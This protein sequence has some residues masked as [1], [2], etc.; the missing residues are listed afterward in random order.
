MRLYRPIV[1]CISL[2]CCAL[3]FGD[4]FDYTYKNVT[5]RCEGNEDGTAKI[6]SFTR[7]AKEVVVPSEVVNPKRNAV[8]KVKTIDLHFVGDA[9]KAQT[10]EIEEGIENINKRCFLEFRSLTKVV[11]PASLQ[12]VGKDAFYNVKNKKCIV[13]PTE[14]VKN[15]LTVSGLHYGDLGEPLAIAVPQAAAPAVASTK[16]A[17]KPTATSPARPATLLKP[18]L[19]NGAPVIKAVSLEKVSNSI[20][21]RIDQRVDNRQELCAIVRVTFAGFQVDYGGDFL[22]EPVV[23]Y[24]AFNRKG[25]DY[26]WLVNK[27]TSLDVFSPDRYFEPA[28]IDFKSVNPAIEKLEGGSV[29]E[30][31]LR[32]DYEK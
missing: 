27:A 13:L 29:Y 26:V 18:N 4:S 7:R 20:A 28:T 32:L 25:K 5:F 14:Q 2:L 31:K 10:L 30:L 11:L 12:F 17:A 15:L 1:L 8:Y 16:P 22:P 3:A 6:T 21:A 9:Y 24:V 19:A 23:N